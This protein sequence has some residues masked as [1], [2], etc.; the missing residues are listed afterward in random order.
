MGK[1]NKVVSI[2]IYFGKFSSRLGLMRI[3]VVGRLNSL[4]LRKWI[5]HVQC[6]FLGHQ[7]NRIQ[8]ALR[9]VS[10]DSVTIFSDMT[11]ETNSSCVMVNM[12]V[13]K[14]GVYSINAHHWCLR[15]TVNLNSGDWK[16][17]WMRVHHHWS[18]GIPLS[19]Q[20]NC[21]EHFPKWTWEAIIV[22]S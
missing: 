20:V 10:N 7:N 21:C 18:S 16:G 11:R 2:G 19:S 15:P 12:H 17:D 8:D 4:S 14:V 5:L 13:F 6:L 9:E 1:V 3:V 22:W